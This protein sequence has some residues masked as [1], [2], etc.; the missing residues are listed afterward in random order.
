MPRGKILND[1]LKYLCNNVQLISENI[2]K[3]F[4]SYFQEF[5]YGFFSYFKLKKC[6]HFL[7]VKKDYECEWQSFLLYKGSWI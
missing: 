6:Y 2:Y 5:F 7:V 4:A 1:D 3:K